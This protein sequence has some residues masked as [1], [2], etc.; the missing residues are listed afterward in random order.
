MTESEQGSVFR[1]ELIPSWALRYEA[2]AFDP[3]SLTVDILAMAVDLERQDLQAL[4]IVRGQPGPYEGMEAWPGGF[5]LWQEDRTGRDAALRELREETGL[6]D[7]AYLEALGTYEEHGR[8]PRQFCG[9]PGADEKT[10]IRTGTRVVSRAYLALLPEIAPDPRPLT[11]SDAAAA[12]WVSVYDF[13]PWEDLRNDA[14]RAMLQRIAKMLRSWANDAH[15]GREVEELHVRIE[16]LFSLN[17]WNE[18][19]ASERW[20]LIHEAKLV[21]EAWR[22]RWGR[23]DPKAPRLLFGRPLAFDHRS[24]LA[25]ALT[26]LRTDIKSSADAAHALLNPPFKL[27][28]LQFAYEAVGGRTLYH[29]NFRRVVAHT[30]ALVEPSGEREEPEGPGKPAA[31]YH[32]SPSRVVGRMSPPLNLPWRKPDLDR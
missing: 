30:R 23:A 27:S 31:L 13:L 4:I 26:R 9:H 29:S 6:R 19:S 22:D 11:G 10:W 21:S 2:R 3:W 7:V 28:E 16:R 20:A 25:D 24:M 12:R 15:R 14:S 5:V 1:G 8:D 18:E 17:A 32:V